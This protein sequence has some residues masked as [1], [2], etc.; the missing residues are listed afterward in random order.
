MK[1]ILQ[2]M[3]DNILFLITLF[4]LVFIP[5]YPKIPLVDI[6]NTWVYVRAEDFVVVVSLVILGIL[7]VRKK[8]TLRTPL[9][10]PILFFWV[11]GAIAT[12]HGVLLIFPEISNV[13]PN[14]ALLS[15]LRRIE[16]LSL[17]F[18]GFAAIRDK[19]A[20]PYIVFVL[21]ATMI[22]VFL[23]GIGQ[24]YLGFPAYLTMNE[25]FA[26]GLPI[27]LSNLGRVPSTFGGHYD[28]AAY[29]VLMIPLLASMVFG[30]RNWLVKLSLLGTIAAGFVLL[31][32]TVSRVSFAVV[33]LSLA[34][35]VFLHKKKW[36]LFSI[37]VV[38]VIFGILL[39]VFSPQLLDRFKSTVKEVDVL[40]DTKTGNAIGNI[41]EITPLTYFKDKNT[42][43]WQRPYQENLSLDSKPTTDGEE[44]LL[45]SPSAQLYYGEL[46]NLPLEDVHMATKSGV[47]PYL[48]LPPQSV[49]VVPPNISGESLP[50]GTGYVNLTLSPIRKG[51]G[52][53][54]YERQVE[55]ETATISGVTMWTGY[56]LVKRASAH[57]LSLTTRYQGE[58]PNAIE[59]FK[60]NIFLGS[61]YGSISLAI[62]NS[63]LRMLGEVGSLGFIAFLVIFITSAAYMKK[64]LSVVDSPIVR[65][66]TIGF[67]GGV[68]GLFLNATLIDVFEASKVAFYLW[69]LM[70][71]TLGMLHLYYTK[72]VNF[73]HELKKVATSTYAVAF[74]LIT[75]TIIF[76]FPMLSNYF[77]ADD[78]TWLR[79][80]TEAKGIESVVQYFT[81]ADGFFYRPGTKLFFLLMYSAFWLDPV[82]YHVASLTLHIIVVVLVFILVQKILQNV[83]LSIL[84]AFVFAMLTSY[85]EAIFWLSSI[86]HVFC[87]MFI[88]LSMLLFTLW[89]EKKHVIYLLAS[90]ISIGA[91][92]LFHELGVV[93]PFMIMLYTFITKESLMKQLRQHKFAYGALFFPI[94]LYLIIRFISRSHWSGGD[95]SYDLLML[96]FNIIGNFFGYVMLS[97]LGP[98]FLNFYELIRNFSKEHLV[99]SFIVI[100]ALLVVARLTYPLIKKMQPKT[101]RIW[102]GSIGFIFVSLLPFL[103]LGNITS[104]YSYLAGFGFVLLF[105]LCIKKLYNYLETSG[106]DVAGAVVTLIISIFF[107]INVIQM[108]QIHADWREAGI[109]VNRFFVSLQAL[110]STAWSTDALELHFV[111][112]PVKVGNAWMF[113][114]GL[115]D[116]LWF[117]FKNP[118]LKIYQ[119]DSIEKPKALI[120]NPALQK[121]FL[122]DEFGRVEIPKKKA[123]QVSQ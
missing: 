36:V 48:A 74:Y 100:V 107:L 28:L 30:F 6:V 101:R 8:V 114:V 56:F 45:A 26:K 22:A 21:A 119:W 25:E 41:K 58:W 65:S 20:L 55:E 73:Y 24:K 75:L 27:Q 59:A 102:I 85:S 90:M 116:A 66:F 110:Y 32:L 17:F 42:L 69:L 82:M 23:Y 84:A 68:F 91:S 83:K 81:Q 47:I 70:G 60:R 93:A 78:F 63:Y 80:A 35:V 121:I 33:F 98:M 113:P 103:G 18:V 64:A 94:V 19:R 79:W 97:L 15:L 16:Y 118:K 86:G 77:V 44:E 117:N 122:V 61:G 115:A 13:F 105:V 37:P 29:L 120:T 62:D 71:I 76:F 49:L 1:K 40:V 53:F 31:F 92:L 43:I 46:M 108:Q 39:L 106:R 88:L 2:W 9:T 14:V 11:I 67:A 5:L 72:Q 7:L 57:D 51:Y 34:L 3:S 95:Y 112:V 89:D 87:V 109:K 123:P 12:L 38:A 111:D 99:F 10:L 104:R 52:E 4:L 54:F 96:P 50:Q